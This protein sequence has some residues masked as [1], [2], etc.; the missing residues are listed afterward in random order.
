[1]HWPTRKQSSKLMSYHGFDVAQKPLRSAPVASCPGSSSCFP[2]CLI[3]A[4]ADCRHHVPRVPRLLQSPR[5]KN[6][7][8]LPGQAGS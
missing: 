4:I 1:V 3:Y 2:D 8:T 7:G 6:L 5:A